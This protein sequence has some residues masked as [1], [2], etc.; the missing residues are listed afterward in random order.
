M[1]KLN[2]NEIQL[3]IKDKFIVILPEILNATSNN[4]FFNNYII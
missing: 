1:K 4:D 3:Y 2:H